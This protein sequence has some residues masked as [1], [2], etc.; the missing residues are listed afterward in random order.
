MFVLIK[1]ELSLT[2]RLCKLLGSDSVSIE[3]VPRRTDVTFDITDEKRVWDESSEVLRRLFLLSTK[4]LVI[5]KKMKEI[6]RERSLKRGG[7]EWIYSQTALWKF[8]DKYEII[9]K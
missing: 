3:L 6:N 8:S 2:D 5:W 9:Q 1:A 7:F 4:L